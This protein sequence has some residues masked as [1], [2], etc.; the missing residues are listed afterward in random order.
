MA[1]GKDSTMQKKA[2]QVTLDVR[3][4]SAIEL[5]VG[6]TVQLDRLSSSSRGTFAER[7]G[8]LL[9]PGVA[10][11]SLE[12]GF[13]S[14]KTLSDAN[15]KVVRGGVTAHANPRIGKDPPPPPPI[16]PAPV[17]SPDDRGDTPS[18]ETPRLTIS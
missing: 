2:L 3:E 18:G 11:L 16:A 9:G 7:H 12:P 8:Q 6:D 10:K 14:F 15:L 17:P 1:T 4:T 5:A 13:Y